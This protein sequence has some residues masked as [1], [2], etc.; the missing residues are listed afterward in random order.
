MRRVDPTPTGDRH[1]GGRTGGATRGPSRTDGMPWAMGTV[2]AFLLL[3][4]GSTAPG[5]TPMRFLDRDEAR[6][7]TLERPSPREKDL[8]FAHV[9]GTFALDGRGGLVLDG[10]KILLTPLTLVISDLAPTA[11][12]PRSRDLRG[13]RGLVFARDS[14]GALDALLIILDPVEPHAGEFR[15]PDPADITHPDWF[16]PS[17]ANPDVGE[18][19]DTA[20]R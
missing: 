9:A 1:T 16:I 5:Q 2:L 8:D 14:L 11:G 12:S 18:A 7:V 19:S 3:A 20:P 13:R 15:A 17:D 4:H 10:R 6:R